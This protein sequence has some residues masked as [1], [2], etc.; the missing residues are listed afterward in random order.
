MTQP[1]DPTQDGISHVNVWSKGKT[2]LG[3]DLSNFSSIGIHHPKFGKF[4]S[5]EGFW[6]WL[7]TGKQHDDLRMMVGYLAKKTGKELARVDNPNFI[8][9]FKSG[10][11]WRLAQNQELSNDLRRLVGEQRLPL[12]HYYVYGDGPNAKVVDVSEK[13][14][15]Q[16]DYYEWWANLPMTQF[17]GSP[18]AFFGKFEND[19]DLIK[20]TLVEQ[21]GANVDAEHWARLAFLGMH[22]TPAEERLAWDNYATQP[23]GK[24]DDCLGGGDEFHK[25]MKRTLRSGPPR[26]AVLKGVF[27]N[28]IDEIVD[29]L[30]EQGYTVLEKPITRMEP[31]VVGDHSDPQLVEALDSVNVLVISEATILKK[32]LQ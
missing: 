31:V 12:K 24:I 25:L 19:L 10:M 1:I 23:E 4:A 9:E 17:L 30:V 11:Y 8:E 21:L 5:L 29:A 7:A 2:K 22:A 20:R 32:D 28:P 3:R 6:Y 18:V 27:A 26:Y 14:Q 16:L 15:W 13:H